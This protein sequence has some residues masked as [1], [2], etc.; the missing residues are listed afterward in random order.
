[1]LVKN[2]TNSTFR[3]PTGHILEPKGQVNLA[4]S[5][6]SHADNLAY[7]EGLRASGKIIVGVGVKTLDRKGPV[8]SATKPMK[9]FTRSWLASVNSYQQL[10]E[11]LRAHGLEPAPAA[12]VDDLRVQVSR[13][14]FVDL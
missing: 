5:V 4:R 12:T 3:F 9:P 6:L 11:L 14:M 1:M 2:N 13:V 7:V 10:A 8:V